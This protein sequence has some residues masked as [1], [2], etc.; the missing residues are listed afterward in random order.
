MLS[1]EC[2]LC[3]FLQTLMFSS[4]VCNKFTVNLDGQSAMQIMLVIVSL[5]SSKNSLIYSV[6]SH[7]L[8][9]CMIY[10]SLLLDKFWGE[11]I[12]YCT[13]TSNS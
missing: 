9:H 5:S 13:C 6:Y 4:I 1:V 8:H 2:F 11:K 7:S 12:K 3:T 10:A